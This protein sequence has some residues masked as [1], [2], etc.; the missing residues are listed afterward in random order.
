[1]KLSRTLIPALTLALAGCGA[2]TRTEYV[3]P[4][5]PLPSAWQQRDAGAAPLTRAPRWWDNFG[6]PQLSQIVAA[7]LETN[8]DL[9]AAGIK[10]RLAR[11]AAGLVDTNQT[12]DVSLSGSASNSKR[13]NGGSAPV[14]SYAASLTLGY[15]LDLWGKLAREREQAAWQV[16]A[17]EYDLR[18]TALTLIGTTAQFYWQI[19]S[20]NQQIGNQQR[21]LEMARQTLAMVQT[22]YEAGGVGQADL[23]QAEQS[24]ISRENQLRDLRE[25]RGEARNGMAILFDRPP[26]WHQRELSGLDVHQQIPVADR[27]PLAVIN[28]RPDVQSAEAGLRAALAGLDAA[29]LSFYPGLSLS[30]GLSAGSA[31]FA[32]WFSDPVRSLGASVALPFVQWNTVQLTIEKSDLS[33]RQAAIAF[34]TT[35]W[36]ALSDVD[37]AM[38]Q[39]LNALSK[40]ESL[41]RDLSLSQRRLALVSSQYRAG[42]VSFQALLD[43]QDALLASENNLQIL[44]YAYLYATMKLW[45]ALGGG[46]DQPP[47]HEGSHYE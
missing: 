16:R 3:R 47:H 19:A 28:H 21:S 45:L 8:G 35:A 41:L 22:R 10:L 12:P 17:S 6:D 5:L 38:A 31:A 42:A 18:A 46:V 2:L 25:Q 24:V 7:A 36:R 4:P 27:V 1:M 15:E 39:R 34:R 44:Q 33:V 9:A 14:E 20:L 26:S 29:R 11:A 13:I 43:A 30:A 32:R 40:K 23:L 37:N